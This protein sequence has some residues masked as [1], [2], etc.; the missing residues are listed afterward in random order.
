MLPRYVGTFTRGRSPCFLT[1]RISHH[2]EILGCWES[3]G[4][5]L[6]C[7]RGA[8]TL[9][10]RQMHISMP[11]HMWPFCLENKSDGLWHTIIGR[12]WKLLPQPRLHI[13]LLERTELR[14]HGDGE[15]NLLLTFPIECTILSC[16]SHAAVMTARG[17]HRMY[18]HTSNIRTSFTAATA[19]D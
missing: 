15:V 8:T 11:G 12:F 6:H 10:S 7:P 3:G 19:A 17:S 2:C 18:I 14:M 5:S 1:S 4:L 9:L 13:E 16:E